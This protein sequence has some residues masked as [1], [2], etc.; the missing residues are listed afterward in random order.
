M[1][2][3]ILPGLGGAVLM[4]MLPGLQA[5]TCSGNGDVVGA[6]GF[7]GSRM[8]SAIPATAPGTSGAPNTNPAVSTTDFGHFI[9]GVSSQAPFGTVGRVLADGAGGFFCECK[10]D[11]GI[12]GA[13]RHVHRKQ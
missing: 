13:D 12:T 5:Q 4:L 3:F 9:A 11:L 10:R 6:Y 7:A 2:R 1:K 8:F